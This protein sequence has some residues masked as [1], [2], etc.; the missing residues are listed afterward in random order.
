VLS[1]ENFKNEKY[2][3]NI[4]LLLLRKCGGKFIIFPV[5]VTGVVVVVLLVG[6]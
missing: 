6:K 5:F 4:Y 2:K 1:Y 3:K